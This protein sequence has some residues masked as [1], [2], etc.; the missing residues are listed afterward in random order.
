[1]KETDPSLSSHCHTSHEL[2]GWAW[3]T[4]FRLGRPP[5]PGGH[6]HLATS[7]LPCG[8]RGPHGSSGQS[9]PLCCLSYCQLLSS[10]NLRW[11]KGDKIFYVF[12]CLV[13]SQ[14][15]FKS[16]YKSSARN[17]KTK[18]TVRAQERKL[19]RGRSFLSTSCYLTESL[20]G[21]THGQPDSKGNES[22]ISVTAFGDRPAPHSA[23][24][25]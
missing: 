13:F 25:L 17:E 11:K 18:D 20:Q 21:S 15:F 19:K 1:V 23:V 7:G 4:P 12:K 8:A 14:V 5:S 6:A 2:A 10:Q 24:G 16:W 22:G 3:G 9:R